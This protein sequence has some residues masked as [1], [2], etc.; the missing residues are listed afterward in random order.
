MDEEEKTEII[1]L[2]PE[3][4]RPEIVTAPSQEKDE[5]EVE[6]EEGGGKVEIQSAKIA[7]P[8]ESFLRYSNN[9]R[10][11]VRQFQLDLQNGR[12]D[13]E[14]LRQ[15]QEAMRERAEGRFDDFKEREFEQFWGQ[16]QKL[17]HSV[18]AGES[19]RVKLE[20]LIQEGLVRKGDVW[21]MSRVFALGR[22]KILVEKEAR[23]SVF[24]WSWFWVAKLRMND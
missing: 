3:D 7:P 11:G 2:L 8:P 14:W 17:V 12:Y 1:N 20:T 18:I 5:S 19:S 16:K 6:G 22:E 9:W 13:R 24:L 10:D 23:V 4:V 21:K 15:A